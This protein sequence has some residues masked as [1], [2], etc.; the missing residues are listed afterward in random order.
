MF[1]PRNRGFENGFDMGSDLGDFFSSFGER[2][3]DFGESIG[4]F[5]GGFGDS[6]G[7][8]F[9]IHSFRNGIF[10]IFPGLFFL[11]GFLALLLFVTRAHRRP[12]T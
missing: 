12:S 9:S 11:F 3:G 4:D 5:F 6:I 2:M 7:D 1:H 8:A 10:F